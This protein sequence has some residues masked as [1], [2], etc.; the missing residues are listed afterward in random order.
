MYYMWIYT[1]GYLKKMI[2]ISLCIIINYIVLALTPSLSLPIHIC[3][4]PWY[5]TNFPPMMVTPYN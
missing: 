5:K 1:G 2:V 4:N 3:G